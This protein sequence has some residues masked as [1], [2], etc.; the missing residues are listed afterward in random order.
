MGKRDLI[1]ECNDQHTTLPEFQE[2]FCRRCKNP[3]CDRA[4]WGDS[5]FADRV[6]TQADRLLHNPVFAD[7]NDPTFNQIRAIHF[8]DMIEQAMQMEIADRRGDWQIPEIAISD[9]QQVVA[10]PDT[11]KVVDDAVRRLAVAQG[12]IP[13]QYPSPEA[14]PAPADPPSAPSPGQPDMTPLY[15]PSP[16]PSAELPVNTPFPTEGVMI[17]DGPSS[18]RMQV[19]AD[20]SRIPGRAGAADP[21][22]VPNDPQEQKVEVGATIR[23]A[24]QEADDE[25]EEEKG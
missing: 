22:A 12:K 10:A 4:E 13:P 18:P 20:P 9:G 8:K 17:G 3:G 14:R 7:P 21:W 6:S 5:Q 19:E 2:A 15:E 23:L 25:E 11:T 1:G 16:P 24:F